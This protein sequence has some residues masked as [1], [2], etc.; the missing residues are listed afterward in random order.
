MLG[1]LVS[2]YFDFAEVQAMRKNPMRMKD[3]IEHLDAILSATGEKL[4]LDAG[5]VSH[6]DAIAKATTEYRKYQV[7]TL[8]PVEEAYLETIKETERTV[9]TERTD[10]TARTGKT[11]QT[12]RTERMEKM[13]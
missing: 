1:N 3:Y 10:R 6:R 11:A 2:G 12:G 5:K 9:K 7:Q 8:S 4:L 13:V